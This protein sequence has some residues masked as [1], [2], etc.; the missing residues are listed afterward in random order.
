[1]IRTAECVSPMHP[2][3][4]CDRISDTLLDL[5]LQHDPTSRVAI[6]TAGGNGL[7]YVTGEVTSEYKITEE[8]ITRVIKEVTTDDTIKVIINL[9]QQSPEISQG[10]DTGGAGDQGIMTGYACRE[11]EQLL[12][13]EY[14]LARELNKFIFEKFPFD[15]KTQITLDRNRIRVV[16]SFQKAPTTELYTLVNEFFRGYP[17]YTLQEIHC[18]PAGPWNIGGFTADAGLTGRKLAVD[19]YGPRI[20]IGGGAFSG[21]D[22]T[23]VDRSA[24]YMARRVAVDLLE[25]D[26]TRNEVFVQLAYAIGYDQPLQATAVIDGVETP[27]EGY[28]LSPQGIIKFLDL[29][30]PIFSESAKFGHMGC[31]FSWK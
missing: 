6:E 5:H 3:K 1:M 15:G 26:E 22:S 4:M 25:Q 17:K 27:I 21:K 11:N 10:V 23:K 31:G 8:E 30:K 7:V 20:P 2:D 28:D 16:A 19:N 13:Q 14:F 18:N 24:A 9:N 12:P 29:R